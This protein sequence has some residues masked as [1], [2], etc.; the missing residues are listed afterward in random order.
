MMFLQEPNQLH[1]SLR[2]LPSQ[3]WWL[4]I[5]EPATS[6]AL[7]LQDRH[8]LRSNRMAMSSFQLIFWSMVFLSVSQPEHTVLLQEPTSGILST[9]HSLRVMQQATA[10]QICLLEAKLLPL[11]PSMSLEPMLFRAPKLSLPSLPTPPMPGSLSTIKAAEI[12]SLP[13]LQD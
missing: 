6:S 9:V 11:L 4:I 8:D 1:Q 13:H 2:T 12:S 3:D 7:L 5:K 10:R